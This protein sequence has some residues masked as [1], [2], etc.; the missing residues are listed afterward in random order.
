MMAIKTT[1]A[2]SRTHAMAL[3]KYLHLFGNFGKMGMEIIMGD[4][5][6]ASAYLEPSQ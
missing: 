3:F 2:V 5:I 1:R 4:K 6:R